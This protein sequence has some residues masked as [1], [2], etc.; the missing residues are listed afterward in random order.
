MSTTTTTECTVYLTDSL[1]AMTNTQLSVTEGQGAFT[2]V[3]INS[4][5]VG[6]I[7]LELIVTLEINDGT[8]S[9]NKVNFQSIKCTIMA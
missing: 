7:E 9:K 2:D 3:C 5:I 6:N 4:G 8:A 1:V